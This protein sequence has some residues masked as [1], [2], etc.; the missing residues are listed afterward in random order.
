[1]PNELAIAIK[2]P[3]CPPTSPRT[4]MRIIAGPGIYCTSSTAASPKRS[5]KTRCQCQPGWYGKRCEYKDIRDRY[6]PVQQQVHVAGLSVAVALLIVSVAFICLVLYVCYCRRR[7]R[8]HCLESGGANLS[9][10]SATAGY[11]RT[12]NGLLAQ[13]CVSQSI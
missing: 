12:T 2:L 8:R 10:G 7:R 9:T 5:R 3:L 6:L 4:H 1:M 13:K 11:D